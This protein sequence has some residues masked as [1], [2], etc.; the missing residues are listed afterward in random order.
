MTSFEKG[1]GKHRDDEARVEGLRF[2]NDDD[3]EEYTLA[4]PH[5]KSPD[6][7]LVSML[8][9]DLVERA[10]N[11]PPL[12]ESRN[13]DRIKLQFSL[14]QMLAIVT[15]A[16]VGLAG[17]QILPWGVFA[18]LVGVFVLVLLFALSQFDIEDPV[19]RWVFVGVV[20]VYVTAALAT[21]TIGC[22]T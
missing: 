12:K 1:S 9:P 18:F 22:V 2:E 5:A 17:T 14:R 13:K 20:T 6:E 21:M 15:F 11:P 10:K 7:V 8:D 4:P 19:S 3:G 16:S